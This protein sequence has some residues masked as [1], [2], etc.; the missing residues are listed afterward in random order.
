MDDTRELAIYHLDEILR[1]TYSVEDDD[2]RYRRIK[3]ISRTLVEYSSLTEEDVSK[4]HLQFD[5]RIDE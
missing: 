5:K 4:I 3:L 1:R 2:E